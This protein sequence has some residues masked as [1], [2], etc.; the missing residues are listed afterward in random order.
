MITLV[1]L[2]FHSEHHIKRLVD[3]IDQQYQII[4]IENSSNKLLKKEIEE[5]Y[6]NVHVEICKENLGFSKGMNLGIKLSKTPYVFLNPADINIS[7]ETINSLS[8]IIK[9]F[10]DFGMLSPV[11]KDKSI[12]SNY[13][14][15]SDKGPNVNVNTETNNYLLKEV[16]FIDGTIIINK[17]IVSNTIFDENMFI[18]FETKDLCKRLI[19]K[20]IKLYVCDSLTFDHYGGQSH[21]KKFNF[22]ASLSRCWHYNWSKFYFNKKHYGYLHALRKSLPNIITSIK[23]YIKNSILFYKEKSKI[24]KELHLAEIKG[25]I[26]SALNMKS[27][28]RPYKKNEL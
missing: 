13:F 10:N 19:E 18:Y 15:W 22:E 26:A 6:K 7:N 24:N 28:Y 4:I 21:D 12:H 27:N 25:I 1:F 3:S 2:S 20:N 16:D 17:N 14:I 11:Y 8:E 23:E 9:K 5:K